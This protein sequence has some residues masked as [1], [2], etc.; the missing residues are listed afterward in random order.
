MRTFRAALFAAL[1]IPAWM[2]LPYIALAQD[3]AAPAPAAP[4]EAPA[5][6]PEATGQTDQTTVN[7]ATTAVPD[8]VAAPDASPEES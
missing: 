8:A 3:P 5:P 2:L 6:T 7:P 1:A 4:A